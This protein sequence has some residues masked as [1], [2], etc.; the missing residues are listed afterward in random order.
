[1]PI[2]GLSADS[3]AVSLVTQILSLRKKLWMVLY[4][5]VITELIDHQPN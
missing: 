4:E 5:R 2:T 1:M 3:T